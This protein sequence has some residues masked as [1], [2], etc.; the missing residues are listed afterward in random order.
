[1]FY[2]IIWVFLCV[3]LIT[4]VIPA[5]AINYSVGVAEGHYVKFGNFL[6]IGPNALSWNEYG[7]MKYEVT[8]I[9]GKNVSLRMTAQFKNGTALPNNGSIYVCNI[10]NYV[11]GSEPIIP[12][13]LTQGEKLPPGP[14]NVTKTEN[15]AYLGVNL[16]VNIVE[17]FQYSPFSNSTLHGTMVYE[18]ASGMILEGRL[19][20]ATSSASFSITE[21][22]IFGGQ[23]IP[24]FA[25][26][27]LALIIMM[28]VAIFTLK[29]KKLEQEEK[30]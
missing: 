4:S 3:L 2:L 24:E 26:T 14:Y 28:I 8:G 16:T 7:W 12:S 22:N 25:H 17:T 27:S 13:N 11:Q 9:S 1:M 10:E 18:K 15:R 29:K 6:G 19:E 30:R 23:T 20:D 21:T 5:S